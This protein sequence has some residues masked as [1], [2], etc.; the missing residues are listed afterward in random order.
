MLV[1]EGYGPNY[2]W[3][4]LFSPPSYIPTDFRGQREGEYIRNGRV[5]NQV[6]WKLQAN[7][8]GILKFLSLE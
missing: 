7:I 2:Y 1:D 6:G 8:M 3:L 5:D 4:I